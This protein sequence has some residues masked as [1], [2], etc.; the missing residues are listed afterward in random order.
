MTHSDNSGNKTLIDVMAVGNGEHGIFIDNPS[1]DVILDGIFACGNSKEF[2][3]QDFD[4]DGNSARIV[5]AEDVTVGSTIGVGTAL[6]GAAECPEY[7]PEDNC[8][9]VSI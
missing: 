5:V 1:G 8:I 2:N 7:E 6:I 4:L 3:H 9:D